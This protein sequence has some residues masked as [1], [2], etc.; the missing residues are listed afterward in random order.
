MIFQIGHGGTQ[1]ETKVKEVNHNIN[2]FSKRKREKEKTKY[3]PHDKSYLLRPS[4][5]PHEP[6]GFFVVQKEFLVR[7]TCSHAAQL[8]IP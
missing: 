8:T 7:S 5:F 6:F 4:P 2:I 3:H 1:K